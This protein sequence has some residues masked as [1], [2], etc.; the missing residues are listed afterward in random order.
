MGDT[1][2]VV[3]A[4]AL[5]LFAPPNLVGHWTVKNTPFAIDFRR[6]GTLDLVGQNVKA[7]G[8]YRVRG[9]TVTIT[10]TR[11]NGVAPGPKERTGNFQIAEGGKALVFKEG[12]R[13]LRLTR[14]R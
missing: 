12:V 13:S 11:R 8:T 10:L 9:S 4:L 7:K 5:A 6:D 1:D 14:S 3:P 2:R